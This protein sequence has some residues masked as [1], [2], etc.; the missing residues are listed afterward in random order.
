MNNFID[1]YR[2]SHKVVDDTV[3]GVELSNGQKYYQNPEE[4]TPSWLS[5]KEY[6]KNEELNIIRLWV[7]FREHI[8]ELPRHKD[9]YYFSFG[10]VGA[11][12][13]G[14]EKYYVLGFLGGDTIYKSWFHVP[15]LVITEN[16][17]EHYSIDHPPK[18]LIV[19]HG[20]K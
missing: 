4:E 19:N 2:H 20:K 1:Y 11:M 8:E 18:G 16:Y 12:F 3:W 13:S 14:T 5:L 15:A 17:T 9:G 10:A 7:Q 6:L